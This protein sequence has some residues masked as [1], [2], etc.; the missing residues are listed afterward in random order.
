MYEA[1]MAAEKPGRDERNSVERRIS[2]IQRKSGKRLC[3]RWQTIHAGQENIKKKYGLKDLFRRVGLNCPATSG[4]DQSRLGASQFAMYSMP[5]DLIWGSS[6]FQ[7]PFN[8][9]SLADRSK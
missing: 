4:E 1:S 5:S 8:P 3:Q 2:R 6:T 7:L 9:S